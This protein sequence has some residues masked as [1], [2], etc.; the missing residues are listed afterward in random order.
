MGILGHFILTTSQ[1]SLPP[2][3]QVSK[4]SPVTYLHLS[5]VKCRNSNTGEIAFELLHI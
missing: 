2:Q 5:I 1:F 4:V 3:P